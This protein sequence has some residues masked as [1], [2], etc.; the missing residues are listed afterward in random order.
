LTQFAENH[1][2]LRGPAASAVASRRVAI[3]A[4]RRPDGLLRIT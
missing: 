1:R 2:D 4:R 3:Q